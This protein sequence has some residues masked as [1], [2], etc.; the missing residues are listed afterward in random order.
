MPDKP[1]SKSRDLT[2]KDSVV[3]EKQTLPTSKLGVSLTISKEALEKID[4]L[5]QKSAKAARETLKM[6][7]R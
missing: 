6:S 4:E 5:E 7:W 1:P 3:E 2:K